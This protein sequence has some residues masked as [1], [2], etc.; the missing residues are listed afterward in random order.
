[1]TIEGEGMQCKEGCQDGQQTT[2]NQKEAGKDSP[3]RLWKEHGPA[4]MWIS[5]ASLRNCETENSVVLSHPDFDTI[6]EQLQET[7]IVLNHYI[8]GRYFETM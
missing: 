6:L 1:M 3:L 2:R 4:G 8:I 7:N 5:A